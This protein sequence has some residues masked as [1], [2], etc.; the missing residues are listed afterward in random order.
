[1]LDLVERLELIKK[2]PNSKYC[3]GYVD[4]VFDYHEKC[5]KNEHGIIPVYIKPDP[6]ESKK[7]KSI[8]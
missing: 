2:K 4:R 3:P 7:K 8:N 5:G 6:I 1:M